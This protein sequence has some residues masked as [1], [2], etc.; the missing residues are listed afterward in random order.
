MRFKWAIAAAL[1]LLTSAAFGQGTQFPA[2]TVWGNDTATQ[3]AGKAA[4]VTAILD[5]AL[6]STRGSILERGASSWAIVG[7]GATAGLP[8]VSAGTGADPAY[9][10]LGL[11][12]GGTNSDLSATGGASQF[13]RQNTAGGAI[14]VIRPVCADLSNAA[15]SCAT[16]ATNASNIG[17]GNLNILR[18]PSI[19][20]NTMIANWTASGAVPLANTIPACANDGAHALVYINGTGLQCESITAGSGNVSAVATPVANQIAQWTGSLTIQGVN[21]NTLLVAGNGINITGTTTP[22]IAVTLTRANNILGA[23]VALNNTSNFFDGP[24]MAQGTSGTWYASGT[25]TV[26][27]TAGAAN[28]DCKL[29]DGT[30][31]ISSARSSINVI[32]FFTASSLSGFITSPAGNIRISCKD[33]ASTSGIIIFNQSGTSKDSSV[34]GIQIQ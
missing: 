28:I 24:S 12:G 30:T 31:V 10:R 27:D 18:F 19:A 4:T 29:W 32:N 21:L 9:Q 16:D 13:L 34:W 7:P 22:T 15:A 20:A 2:G 14:T 17:S 25:V 33:N 6:G 3:R 26:T 23:N 1:C 8:W 5:R 11:V